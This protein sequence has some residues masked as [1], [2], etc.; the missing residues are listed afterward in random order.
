MIKRSEGF[1]RQLVLLIDVVA[2]VLAFLA[3]HYVRDAIHTFYRLDL[4]PGR[5]VLSPIGS[6]DSYLWLL[7][8]IIPLWTGM[9]YL[10]GGYHELRIKAYRRMGWIVLKA[11]ALGLLGFG[12]SVFVFKL[13]YVSRTFMALFFVVSFGLLAL[14]RAFLIACFHVVL[15]CGY[16][17]RNLLIVGTGQRARALIKAVQSHTGWG[18]RVIGLLDDDL[19]RAVRFV[20]EH[21]VV[22]VAVLGTLAQLPSLLRQHVVDE[23]IFVVPR[24]WMSRIEPAVL[25]CEL[26]GVRATVAV[27]LF[28]TRLARSHLADLNGIPLLSFDTTPIDEW[29][30]ALKRVLDVLV[31]GLGLLVLLLL[32][33]II[34]ALIK[35][36]SPGPVFFRQVRSGLNGRQFMLYKFRSMVVDAETQQ[37]KLQALNELN[38]PVFKLT[39]DPRLTPVGRWL[40]KT[41]IDELPQLFNVLK[42][43]MSLVGPRPLPTYEVARH[44]AWQRRRL[45]IPPGIT[46]YWQVNG[47]NRVTDFDEW[48]RLDLEYIDRWSLALDMKIL[49]KT[50]PAVLSGN[51]AK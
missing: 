45:S 51:G 24:S 32:F 16:F 20:A 4:I 39:N 26:A 18:L 11:S 17:H 2:I 23:V 36:T 13:H 30:L 37:A 14:E 38:G 34:A 40:R 48:T 33:P 31:S 5:E 19:K 44:E 46:G 6:L 42:G 47:R 3:T 9:L 49:L 12:A 27:D 1:L 43:Q 35:A 22:G 8:I 41:S 28:N 15:R 7:L 21:Q 29:Q 25:E 50:I 10:L